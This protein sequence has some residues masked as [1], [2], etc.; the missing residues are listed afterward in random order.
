MTSDKF[1]SKRRKQGRAEEIFFNIEKDGEKAIDDFIINRQSEELFLDFKRSINDGDGKYIDQRDREILA[2]CISGFG[3][4]EGGVIVWGVD[5]SQG[6]DYSDVA[7]AKYPIKN[8]ARFRSW[9]ENVIS[10]CTIPPHNGVQNHHI[11]IDPDGRGFVVTYIPKSNYAPHQVISTGRYQN[12]YYIRV[13]SSFATTPHSVLAGMFGKRPE[14]NV[15]PMFT[16]GPA[17]IT[18]DGIHIQLGIMITNE[19][20]GIASDL[21]LNATIAKAFGDNSKLYFDPID[22]ADWRSQF[23][24]GIILHV[25]SKKDFRLAPDSFVQ[26]VII[27]AVIKPPFESGLRINITCGCGQSP[28][29]KFTLESS[30]EEIE[31]AYKDYM[32]IDQRKSDERSARHDFTRIIFGLSEDEL[33]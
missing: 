21:F 8:V 1:S 6:E 18:R 3:N 17:T 23:A 4:S 9:I 30:K 24:F 29:Y 25:I 26:P 32:E 28:S 27:N 10:S 15:Y 13:G 14:P 11:K 2:R 31:N 12:H 20:P 33:K 7:R 16:L 22:P 5:C 19:G